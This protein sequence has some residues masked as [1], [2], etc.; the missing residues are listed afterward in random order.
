MQIYPNNKQHYVYSMTGCVLTLQMTYVP[1]IGT[2]TFLVTKQ[3]TFTVVWSERLVPSRVA[4]QQ[5]PGFYRPFWLQARWSWSWWTQPSPR[6][7][8]WPGRCTCPGHWSPDRGWWW[9]CVRYGWCV[10]SLGLSAS[11]R[12]GCP[13]AGAPEKNRAKPGQTDGYIFGSWWT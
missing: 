8:S 12:S 6:A 9:R 10:P 2:F 5:G 13:Q 11:W 4:S 3:P 7:G 1:Q